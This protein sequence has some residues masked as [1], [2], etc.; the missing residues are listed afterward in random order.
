M[1]H[2]YFQHVLQ[3]IVGDGFKYVLVRIF[4]LK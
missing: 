3:I 4:V 1:S 2:D